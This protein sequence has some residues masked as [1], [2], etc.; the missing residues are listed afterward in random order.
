MPTLTAVLPLVIAAL[1]VFFGPLIQLSIAKRQIRATVLSANRQRWIDEL[2]Q[3]LAEFV[4]L[5]VELNTI[6]RTGMY[7]GQNTLDKT[8]KMQLCR[9][10]IALMLNPAEKD[11]QLLLVLVGDAAKGIHQAGYEDKT[12]IPA[13]I[14]LSQSIL[15]REWVRVKAAQ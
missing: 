8:A 13:F 3:L 5:A 2:R 11:H 9:T 10:K 7:S 12:D 4:T 6:A 15:K 14:A 1:A